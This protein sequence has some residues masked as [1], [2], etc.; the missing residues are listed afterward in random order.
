MINLYPDQQEV[1][2]QVQQSMVLGNKSVLMQQATGAGKTI[3]AT[4]ILNRAFNKDKRTWFVVPRRQLLEQTHKTYK[5]FNIPH[6]FIASNIPYYDNYK[7][8]IVSLNT[9][10]RRIDEIKI[11]DLVV[12]DETHYGG[13]GLDYC[14][15]KVKDNGSYN[16]GLSATPWKLSGEGLG[17]WY[18]DMVCGPSIRWLMDNKRL[19]DYELYRPKQFDL[20]ELRKKYTQKELEAIVKGQRRYI[21][22]DAVDNYKKYALGTRNVTFCVSVEESQA[23]AQAYRDAGIS[24]VHV[25]GDTPTDEL[26][27]IIIAFANNQI[28][29]LCN[30]DL[31]TFGFDLA[32]W[33]G[34]DVTVESLTDLAPTQSLA[35][36]LQKWGRVLRYKDYKAIIIDSAGN[37]NEDKHG[38]PCQDRDWTLADWKEKKEAIRETTVQVRTCP[39]CY[40]P[41]RAHLDTCPSCGHRHETV[42]RTIEMIEGELE[43]AEITHTKKVKRMEVGQARTVEDLWRIAKERGYKKGWV[44]TQMKLKK[45]KA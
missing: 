42:G 28:D 43:K 34:K 26:R 14:I 16:I 7:M 15:N 21:V 32:A 6:G 31:L 37:S 9:L 27:A 40:F 20:S 38:L 45:I 12:W 1:I 19:S 22:G 5:K 30:C 2:D 24:A 41:H 33:A 18:D 13:E 23:T 25:D 29:V 8:H 36:Q 11:P 3:C 35:K 39:R 4:Y 44:S 10:R 17:C